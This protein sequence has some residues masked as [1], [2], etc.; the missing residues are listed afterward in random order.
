[1]T[2]LA[3]AAVA[4]V[5]IGVV[6][7]AFGGYTD[8]APAT[9]ERILRLAR[10]MGYHPSE[11]GRLLKA[12]RGAPQRCAVVSL[13]TTAQA[14]SRSF[15]LE[16]ILSGIVS[17]AGAERLEVHLVALPEQGANKTSTLERLVAADT[18]DGFIFLTHRPIEPADVAPLDRAKVPYVLANR[19]LGGQHVACVT[20]DR[21]RV[22]NDVVE[23]LVALGHRRM[24]TIVHQ[25]PTS[26]ARDHEAGWRAALAACGI[27]A[28]DAPVLRLDEALH[29]DID[30][31]RDLAAQVLRHGL[32]R[33]PAAARPTAIACFSDH[34]AYGVLQAAA[35]AGVHVPGQLSVI[36]FDD[37][38]APYTTPQLCTYNAH[39]YELGAAAATLLA[40]LLRG[41][42]SGSR[43][44]VITPTFVCRK[45]CGPAPTRGQ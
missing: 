4:G 24:A 38:I 14:L 20:I 8:I 41:E 26:T 21:A 6:S 22:A 23:R 27:A 25:L 45:S 39:L 44:L 11:R 43:H 32:P 7:R 1:M 12:G 29:E 9:R 5:S 34:I 28:E 16:T 42:A 19:D 15:V 18:A 37:L 13:G 30:H 2:A 3:V 40:Q 33:R 17:R 35:A 31:Y 36:G 10:D